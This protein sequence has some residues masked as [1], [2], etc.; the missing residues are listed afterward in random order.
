MAGEN[1]EISG[2]FGCTR[3]PVDPLL[4][5]DDNTAANLDSG[6]DSIIGLLEAAINADV[7]AAYARVISQ[8]SPTHPMRKS[9]GDKPVN[10][11]IDSE[12]IPALTT[13]LLADWPLLAVW[14]T[15]E[16]Q[17][18]EITMAMPAL[19]QDWAVGYIMSPLDVAWQRKLG[20]GICRLVYRSVQ[21]AIWRGYH[22][23]YQGGVRQFYGQFSEIQCKG[24]V[25][26]GVV[27]ILD[28]EKGIGYYGIQINLQTV[29]RMY[30]DD[31][32]ETEEPSNY[33]YVP[34]GTANPT[35]DWYETGDTVTVDDIVTVNGE[36]E[37]NK[38]ELTMAPLAQELPFQTTP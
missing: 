5:G 4:A 23:A 14:P 35:Q 24:C 18:F 31:L 11:T 22:P 29:E 13:Q 3:F 12:P 30:S 7:G 2:G 38:I 37:A 21:R 6:Q 1:P 15:G 10:F 20:R 27:E 9:L 25:G 32:D 28:K 19:R 36:T 34:A 26:P 33:G 16:P 8:L 17:E